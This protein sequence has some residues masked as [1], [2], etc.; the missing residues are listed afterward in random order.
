MAPRSD[1]YYQR[2][3]LEIR[4]RCGRWDGGWMCPLGIWWQLISSPLLTI[5]GKTHTHIY[6]GTESRVWLILS[7]ASVLHG[8][9]SGES[10][11]VKDLNQLSLDVAAGPRYMGWCLDQGTHPEPLNEHYLIHLTEAVQ[12]FPCQTKRIGCSLL[13]IDPWFLPSFFCV[14]FVHNQRHKGMGCL[15]V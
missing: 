12:V 4:L 9:G 1:F 13:L 10:W 7:C 11:R 2:W 14:T 5:N 8:N 15:G 6:A 3:P